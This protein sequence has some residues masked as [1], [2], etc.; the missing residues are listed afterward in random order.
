MRK[1]QSKARNIRFEQLCH[2]W[3]QG[4]KSTPRR[5]LDATT[6]HW[7]FFLSFEE[8]LSTLKIG[9]LQTTFGTSKVNSDPYG[10]GKMVGETWGKSAVDA[11]LISSFIALRI[12]CVCDVEPQNYLKV[13]VSQFVFFSF[14]ICVTQCLGLE[15]PN[16][17]RQRDQSFGR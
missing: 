2:V 1:T 15:H 10:A 12:G 6:F 5:T 17:A 16:D 9:C 3:L 7:H 11:G 4:R 14:D 13:H 8:I